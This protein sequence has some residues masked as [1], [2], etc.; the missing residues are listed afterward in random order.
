MGSDPT[1]LA[2]EGTGERQRVLVLLEHHW[3]ICALSDYQ[4]EFPV[5][6]SL[7]EGSPRASPVPSEQPQP[8]ASPGPLAPQVAT[9]VCW[10]GCA[11]MGD[12]HA[13]LWTN[14]GE[15]FVFALAKALGER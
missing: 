5:M 7:A 2:V 12:T 11:F 9:Y 3:F 14:K 4:L 6:S 1:A 10:A 15:V 13:A 8:S